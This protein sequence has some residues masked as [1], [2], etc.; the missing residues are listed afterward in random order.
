[1]LRVSLL[2]PTRIWAGP[3]EIS[4]L[5]PKPAA[6][7]AILAARHGR[8][9]TI[10]DLLAAVWGEDRPASAV[11]ALRNYV[12]A[13]RRLAAGEVTIESVAEGYRLSGGIDLD[14]DRFTEAHAEAAALCA[15][16]HRGDADRVARTALDLWRG[17]PLEGVPGGWAATER[18]R[19]R[20]IH[21]ALQSI[22]LEVELERG[23]PLRA[24]VELGPLVQDNPHDERLPALLMTA[25]HR[26]GRRAEALELY[27]EV[28]RGLTDEF[29][30]EPGPGLTAVHRSIL[31]DDPAPELPAAAQLPADDGDFTGRTAVLTAIIDNIDRATGTVVETITGM[32]GVGKTMVAI[33]IGHLLA[34]RFPDGRLFADLHGSGGMRPRAAAAVL[35]EFL[36]AL[37]VPD[38]Q[39]PD[40]QEERT[41][42]YRSVLSGRRVLIILDNALDAGQVSP[43]LP[44]AAGCAT[45]LTARRPIDT[46]AGGRVH[47]LPMFDDAEATE[48]VRRVVGP[49]RVQAEPG[50]CANLVARCGH[51]PLAIHIAATR[52]AARPTRTLSAQVAEL[53][54]RDGLARLRAGGRAVDTLF[55]AGYDELPERERRLFRLCAHLEIPDITSEVAAAVLRVSPAAAEDLCESLVDSGML[56]SWQRGRFRYHDLMRAFALTLAPDERDDLDP[57]TLAQACSASTSSI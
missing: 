54:G 32:G 43:L 17:A 28:H 25:L 42:L 19:L 33:R 5:P 3:Q 31:A 49:A 15:G 21:L 47:H 11:S 38:A 18:V 36:R 22:A 8:I 14:I 26:A 41:A 29:G 51:L 35:G 12:S 10:V 50:A 6:V 53:T 13:L 34:D 20:E 24:I 4:G 9:V 45:I 44:G 52:I 1:M 57:A 30:V 55:R 37:G 46:C 2:G 27:R 56:Q 16:P 48:L 40:G 23:D 39:I 7:L